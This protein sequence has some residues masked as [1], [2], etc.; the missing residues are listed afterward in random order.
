MYPCRYDGSVYAQRVE[1]WRKSCRYGPPGPDGHTTPGAHVSWPKIP[2]AI[3]LLQVFRREF[4]VL[5]S[6]SPL[7]HEAD[8]ETMV[9]TNWEH[10]SE[11]GTIP[12]E[13]WLQSSQVLAAIGARCQLECIIGN[14]SR[15]LSCTGDMRQYIY[16]EG[17][18][19]YRSRMPGL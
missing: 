4:P 6:K 14:V 7:S 10:Y 18:T 19:E 12:W 1:D 17:C 2:P 5:P 16:L 11:L 3:I 13:H 15:K 9:R 8:Y